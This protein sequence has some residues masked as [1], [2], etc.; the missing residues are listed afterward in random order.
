ST[1]ISIFIILSYKP[2]ERMM[3]IEMR[4]T[5]MRVGD[6][7]PQTAGWFD[8]QADI[9]PTGL[10]NTLSFGGDGFVSQIGG[11]RGHPLGRVSTGQ[12]IAVPNSFLHRADTAA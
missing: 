3:K 2:L 4:V 11:Q 12:E 9:F 1:S 8:P 10:T 6:P 5:W 7:N